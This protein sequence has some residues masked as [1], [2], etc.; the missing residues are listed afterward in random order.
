[1]AGGSGGGRRSCRFKVIENARASLAVKHFVAGRAAHFLKHVRANAHAAGAAFFVAH[2]GER[3]VVVLFHDAV[4]V[5]QHVF[6]NFRGGAG[7]FG[8][9]FG[10]L[11]FRGGLFLF[12]FGALAAGGFFHFFQGFVGGFDFAVIFFPRHHLLEQAV[13]RFGDFVFG[14]LHFVLQGFVRFVG[15]YLGGLIFALANAVFPLFLGQFLFL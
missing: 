15:F 6:G 2:F 13:F 8:V 7:A 10:Q 5:V 14:V 9:A 4:V 12:D 1:M 3:H 11:F